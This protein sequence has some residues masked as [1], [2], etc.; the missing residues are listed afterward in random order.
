MFWRGGRALIKTHKQIQTG[1]QKRGDTIK[2]IQALGEGGEGGE[3]R[4]SHGY[5]AQLSATLQPTSINLC[6]RHPTSPTHTPLKI[7]STHTPNTVV[8]YPSHHHKY[9]RQPPLPVPA[10]HHLQLEI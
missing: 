7:G 1:E 8:G 6:N 10:A 9:Q 2:K 3:G 5:R 4:G